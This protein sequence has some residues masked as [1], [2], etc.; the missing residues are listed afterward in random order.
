MREPKLSFTLQQ[1]YNLASSFRA[2]VR[3]ILL[4]PRKVKDSTK[5]GQ[6]NIYL[7]NTNEKTMEI[8]Q[9]HL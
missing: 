5:T 4:K 8:V 1:I 2:E 7:S 3:R 9:E 6:E